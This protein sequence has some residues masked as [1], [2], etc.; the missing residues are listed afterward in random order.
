V[1]IERE[2]ARLDALIAPIAKQ[3]LDAPTAESL[4][5]M[6]EA[7]PPVIAPEVEASAATALRALLTSY[8]EGDDAARAGIRGL[9]NRYPS[10]R[11]AATLSWEPTAEDFRLKVLH[12]SAQDQGNDPRDE[13]LSLQH[14]CA[15]ARAAG[16]DIIPILREVAELSSDVDRYGMG[17]TREFL[18]TWMDH[19]T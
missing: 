11:W 17:S 15:K 18:R 1:D 10:F 12:F 4:R 7:G 9:F 16:I 6:F 3:P 8:A 2:V 19:Q 14:W 5:A 13:L